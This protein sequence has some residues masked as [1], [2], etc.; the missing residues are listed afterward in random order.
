MKTKPHRLQIDLDLET[1][2]IITAHAK[3]H[4]MLPKPFIE[5]II[6][7]SARTLPEPY[8]LGVDLSVGREEVRREAIEPIER[9]EGMFMED[10]GPV[11]SP[12]LEE[13]FSIEAENEPEPCLTCGDING[14]KNPCCA[15]YDPLH[16][17]NCGYG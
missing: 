5:Y 9:V 4:G 14:M 12:A 6:K 2:K 13:E 16:R 1:L 7:M 10:I 3:N 11:T 8:V 17:D 15:G